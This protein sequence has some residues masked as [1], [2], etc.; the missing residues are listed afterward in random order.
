MRT[1]CLR[2]WFTALCTPIPAALA[3]PAY[4]GHGDIAGL[5]DGILHVTSG[6]VP[7]I[8]AVA[9]GIWGMANPWRRGWLLPVAFVAAMAAG[10]FAGLGRPRE[11]IAGA[12][13]VAS[14]VVLGAL[15]LRAKAFSVP[16]A[17]V[18]CLAFGAVHGYVHGTEAG[19]SGD[20]T[21]YVAGLAIAT[22]VLHVAG[23]A[24]G[25]ML[26]LASRYGLR[27]AGALVAIAGLWF[28]TGLVR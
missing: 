11:E 15:I 20:T 25:L 6:V 18:I 17:V 22:A 26:R 9:V 2:R 24:L 28:A 12:M 21:A 3:A 1:L 23:M 19:T 4:A 5:G 27:A 14:L 10:A 16:G 13:V 7:M 8:A